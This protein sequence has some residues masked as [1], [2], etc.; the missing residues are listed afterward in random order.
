MKYD[1]LDN[2]GISHDFP[3]KI[4]NRPGLSSIKYRIGTYSVFREALLAQLDRAPNLSHWTYRKGDDPGIALLEGSAILADI[5]TFYQEQYINE[6]FLGTARWKQSIQDLVRLTGYRLAPGLGGM[7]AFAFEIKG[8]A[9]LTVAKLTRLKVQL[10]PADESAEFETVAELTAFNVLNCF[11]LFQPLQISSISSTTEELRIHDTDTPV[12]IVPKDRIFLGLS[13]SLGLR[14]TTQVIAEQARTVLDDTL[15]TFKGKLP[16]GLTGFATAFKLHRTFNHFGANSPGEIISANGETVTTS[17]I[18]FDRFFCETTANE[19]VDHVQRIVE[20]PLGSF[21]IPLDSQVDDIVPG[22]WIIFEIDG[23]H[24]HPMKVE[25]CRSITMRWG[26]FSGATTMLGLVFAESL[27]DASTR[28]DI[29]NQPI[30]I[31]TITIHEVAGRPF[32]VSGPKTPH[33]EE[34]NALYYYGK[35]E[36]YLSLLNR[37]LIFVKDDAV[38]EFSIISIETE[39]HPHNGNALRKLFL[40]RQLREGSSQ[41]TPE[42]FALEKE[43]VK[44]FGNVVQA[45]QGKL[46]RETI[47]GNGDCRQTFQTFK[48][49]KGPLT[50]HAEAESSPPEQPLL[51]IYVGDHTWQRVDS[52]FG[53]KGDEM[54]YIV[55]EDNEGTSWVQFGD[56]QTGARLP[57]GVDNVVA[58]YRTGTGSCGKIK[59]D[60]SVQVLSKI[61]RLKKTHLPGTLI[62]GAAAE[63]GAN[64]RHAAPGKV[65]SLDR[66]V[67]LQDIEREALSISGVLKASAVRQY[68]DNCTLVQ[69]TVLTENP[70]DD[71]QIAFVNDHIR[72]LNKCSGPGRFPILVKPGGISKLFI[73]LRYAKSTSRKNQLVERD[74]AQTLAGRNGILNPFNRHFGKP[75]WTNRITGIIQEM[76]DIA[77]VEIVAFCP[78]SALAGAGVARA[79]LHER[80]DCEASD[81]LCL[82]PEHIRIRQVESNTIKECRYD[83]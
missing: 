63:T 53:K 70:E 81:I 76:Y 33:S 32:L 56:G 50:Y 13:T 46:E 21:E 67:T 82:S 26:A 1:W 17:T 65:Q 68:I 73:E 28:P 12:S 24:H 36:D 77:W 75:E 71:Q 80:I 54:V 59:D 35:Y 51:E 74:I 19:T 57:S 44:V 83:G 61:N 52:L 2:C 18:S 31:R 43:A 5:L 29:F 25:T 10:Q 55:R 30:D 42:D 41:F 69:V 11:S 20:P 60:T 47:L 45:R 23:T 66:L 79:E 4:E 27:A 15:I 22:T 40:N 6:A 39:E 37:P 8:D 62:G 58:R 14:N 7:A 78:V 34:D 48:L 49:P 9:P 16:S 72:L 38:E 64:A 3:K